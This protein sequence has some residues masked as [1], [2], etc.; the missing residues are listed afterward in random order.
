MAN[1]ILILQNYLFIQFSILLFFAPFYLSYRFRHK[2]NELS[3]SEH[4]E[5][6]FSSKEA[7]FLVFL[8]AALEAS[9]WFVIPEFL[10]LLIIF[11]RIKKKLQLFSYD[12]AGT[13]AGTILAFILPIPM[14]HI[15]KIP[16]IQQHMVQQV[17]VWYQGLGIFGLIFQPLSGVPYKVFTL[18]AKNQ[19]F[20]LPTFI[21]MAVLVRI[22][23]YYFFY[24]IFSNIYPFLHRFVYKNYLPL[25]IIACFIFTLTLLKVYNYY[26]E[27]YTIEYSSID[28]LNFMR[29]WLLK[30]RI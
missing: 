9:V 26:G 10:L 7:N 27:I 15:S 5:Y 17:E 8:W 19:V 16:Y 30:F 20:F 4:L 25:F 11:L 6:F 13:I 23:R 12:V 18:V 28:K 21:L 3:F 29:M 24:Y 1:I 22:T 2:L 14:E